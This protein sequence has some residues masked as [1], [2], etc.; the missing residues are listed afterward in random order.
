[1]HNLYSNESLIKLYLSPYCSTEVTDNG[2]DI[3]QY[4]FDKNIVIILTNE[5]AEKLLYRLET[6][7]LMT[8]LIDFLAQYYQIDEAEEY[9]YF[10][11]Q[12]GVLE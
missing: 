12:N 3:Y 5:D 6:G 10:M 11:M 8:E 7:M 1:M 4:L 2:L 9:V